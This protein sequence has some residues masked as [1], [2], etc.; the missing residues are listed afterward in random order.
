MN[1]QTRNIGVHHPLDASRPIIDA[2]LLTSFEPDPDVLKASHIVAFNSRDL[3]SRP[4]SLLRTQLLKKMEENGWKLVGITS[5]TPGAGKS[6]LAANLAASLS[7][8]P[9]RSTYLFDFDLRRSSLANSFG[10]S[11]DYGLAEYLAGECQDLSNFGRK[12]GESRLSIYP[13]YG[14]HF[15]SF[16]LLSGDRCTNLIESMRS[17]PEDAIVLCDLP[18]A[19]ANDDAMVIGQALDAYIL[20]IEQGVTNS[21]Q[22]RDC[23]RLMEPTPCLGSVLNRYEGG[24]GDPYGYGY[25]HG[26]GLKYGSYYSE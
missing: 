11:G 22:V 7:R 10:M 2:N 9:N 4:F 16:E 13:S 20:V 24:I 21:N 25:G 5:P 8:L 6:F 12:I 3:K 23:V 1:E 15:D 18:P 26:Y 17:V 14:Q 19:F